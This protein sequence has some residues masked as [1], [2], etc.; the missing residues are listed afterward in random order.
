MDTTH[1]ISTIARQHGLDVVCAGVPKTIDNDVGD[2]AFKLIDHTPGYGSTARYWACIVQNADEENRGS[3]PADPVLVLQAMGRKI[4]YIPAAARLAD[5]DREMPLQIYMAESGHSIES[6]YDNVCRQLRSSGRCIVVISEGFSV[7]DIGE[8][9][10]AFGHTSFDSSQMKVAQIVTNYLNANGLPVP[11]SARCQMPG[12]DQ[13]SMSIYASAVDIQEAY[14]VGRK[15]VDIAVNDGNGWMATILR[16][17]GNPYSVW[18]DKVALD[19]V[20]NSERTFP[21]EWITPDGLD[22][23][24]DFIAYARPLIGDAWPVVPLHNGLQRYTRF[25]MNFADKRL[26]DYIPQ[27]YR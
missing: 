1:K 27:T 22:V 10:D 9:K 24:D 5:P 15:A 8:V 3:C 17:P 6:L 13:R 25:S 18:Y 12:T 19:L 7:G 4:G 20:A 11:G 23:T 2:S 26:P 16:K 21:Q 14:Q